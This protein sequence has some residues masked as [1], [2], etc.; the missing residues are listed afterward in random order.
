MARRVLSVGNCGYDHSTLTTALKKHFDVEMYAAASADAAA[1]ALDE[2][3]FDLVLVNREFDSTGESGIELIKKLKPTVKAPMML[4]SN[5][6][7]AQEEAVAAGAVP[8][9]GKK[10]VGKPGM[11]EVV[12]GYLR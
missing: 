10:M 3:M 12:E 11:V 4:I 8:G 9:F 5:F 1:K 2:D 7:E 6:P